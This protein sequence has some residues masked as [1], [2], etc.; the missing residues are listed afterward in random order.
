MGSSAAGTESRMPRPFHFKLLDRMKLRAK[1]AS[2]FLCLS[3]LIGIC[4]ASGL[5]FIYGIGSTL[6]IFA[7][8]TS[9]LLGQTVVLA[10]NAQ[11]MRGVFLDALNRDEGADGGAGEALSELDIAA[12]KGMDK[13]RTLLDE[14]KLVVR[15]GEIRGLQHDFSQGLFA[16]LSAHTQQRMAA[17]T[18]QDR[19]AQFEA[20]R[21]EF[22]S[23]LRTITARGEAAM[24]RARD[25]AGLS[26]SAGTAT[27]DGL[28]D[29]FS[30]TMNEDYPLVQG[31]YKLTRDAVTLQEVATAYTNIMQPEA[32]L[33]IER[34]A[35]LTFANAI[36]V[37]DRI[38][39]R[40]QSTE[41][42]GYVTRFRS[43]LEELKNKLMGKEGLFAAH[44]EHLKA[45]GE[46][47][48]MQTALAIIETRYVS[49]LEEVRQIVEKH[50]EGAKARAAMMVHQALAS[51]G[52]LMLAGLLIGLAF[53]LI[54]T[55]RI[56]G[57][58]TRITE[59]M[60]RLAAGGLDVTVPARTRTDEIGDMAA[61]LQVF[62]DNAI[63]AR[64]LVSERE[65]EQAGKEERTQRVTE[66]CA[67][68]ERSITGLLRALN[69]AATDMRSTSQTMFAIVQE[70]G[71]Q[72]MAAAHASQEANTNVQTAAA[73]TEELS[74]STAQI[75]D[76]ALHSAQ[77]AN[78]AAEETERAGTVVQEL[79][80]T[81]SE[82]GEVVRMIEEIAS[83]TNLLALNATI[84]AAR[85]G[86]AGRGFGVVAGEVKNLAGQTAKATADIAA[87]VA[88]IQSATEQ[89][90]Q[91]IQG[92]R[93]TIGEMREISHFVA[94]TM[95]NQS[96][97]T[98]EIAANTGLVASATA[99]V[100]A[101]A[102]SVSSS[103]E[104]TGSAANQVVEAAIDLNRQAEALR[105]EIGSFLENIRAA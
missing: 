7:D 46:L 37:V 64:G 99:Q 59:T 66:L 72:A 47:S 6:S 34:R 33:V 61:A 91:A 35:T 74:S 40:L 28:N 89:A 68:H 70:T 102:E 78:K 45:R 3:L 83:Q 100:T 17:F 75:N 50:N 42:Q 57:P 1:L 77:I 30:A 103:M 69:S 11:R 5:V 22:D 85:A 51:I 93:G 27:I 65:L 44:R 16:M 67:A 81:A 9:P 54:F 10:D 8:I 32:L 43:G 87:R 24:S 48:S 88:A 29:L 104:S 97:A 26:V 101:N 41:G 39:G 96:T 84:E 31:L 18:V 56:V 14:A 55:R 2:A 53:S 4:G 13:L 21:R 36:D 52:T 94:T 82:I 79:H 76:R 60:T 86:E 105:T 98:N 15:V 63:E 73:A 19:L 38:A 95:E 92:V 80:S 62:K 58:I 49:S 25:Q 90:V 20:D 12:G 71:D 23:L